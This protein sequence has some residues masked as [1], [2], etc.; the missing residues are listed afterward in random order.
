MTISQWHDST[1]AIGWQQCDGTM[2]M[3]R[4]SIA[5]SFLRHSTIVIES[6]QHRAIVFFAQALFLRKCRQMW[7]FIRHTLEILDR[8]FIPKTLTILAYCCKTIKN[9]SN[10]LYFSIISIVTLKISLMN[11]VIHTRRRGDISYKSYYRVILFPWFCSSC[12]RL[13][14]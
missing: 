12:N 1:V 6:S 14:I 10:T 3:T 8:P 4:C 2:T 11:A 9:V 7:I 13:K 5:P